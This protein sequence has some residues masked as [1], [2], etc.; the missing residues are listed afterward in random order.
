M[1]RVLRASASWGSRWSSREGQL[2]RPLPASN[3]ARRG[4]LGRRR[5]HRDGPAHERDGSAG[6]L[7]DRQ[8]VDVIDIVAEPADGATVDLTNVAFDLTVDLPA[9][10][11]RRWHEDGL[12]RRASIHT[13]GDHAQRLIADEPNLI[14]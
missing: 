2:E 6:L 13:A 8:R 10:A 14:R 7:G 5:T 11:Q 12:G 9:L 1:A 4:C 3:V